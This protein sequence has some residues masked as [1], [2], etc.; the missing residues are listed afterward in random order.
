LSLEREKYKNK[1]KKNKKKE[2]NIIIVIIRG[3]TFEDTISIICP[4][5]EL[6]VVNIRAIWCIFIFAKIFFPHTEKG[7]FITHMPPN[8]HRYVEWTFIKQSR[9]IFDAD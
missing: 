9:C 4:L 3:T 1:K 2:K 6:G 8:A 7:L 5:V